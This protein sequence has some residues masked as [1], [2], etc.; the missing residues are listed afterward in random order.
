MFFLEAMV[1][2]A[3]IIFVLK[4]R[5]LSFFWFDLTLQKCKQWPCSMVSDDCRLGVTHCMFRGHHDLP[6]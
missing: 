3:K 6:N 1:L 5:F 2:Q 4:H